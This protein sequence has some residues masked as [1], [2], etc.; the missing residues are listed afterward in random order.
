MI[1]TDI[2]EKKLFITEYIKIRSPT[3]PARRYIEE[4]D[5]AGMLAAK[6]STGVTPEVNL[7]EHVM[8]MSLPSVNKVAHSGFETQRRCHQKSKRR[9]S[10]APKKGLM[11]SK[12]MKAEYLVRYQALPFITSLIIWK[13][14]LQV[15]SK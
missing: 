4:I 15:S 12:M 10:V 2:Y 11:S 13:S 5:S 6:R 1:K 14:L 7:R 3:I 8:D 9:V